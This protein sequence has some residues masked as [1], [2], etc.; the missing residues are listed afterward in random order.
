MN[1][2]LN[3]KSDSFDD[4]L[5]IPFPNDSVFSLKKFLFGQRSLYS[6]ILHLHLGLQLIA[7][8]TSQ[9]KTSSQINF[10]FELIHWLIPAVVAWPHCFVFLSK[11]IKY[12]DEHQQRVHVYHESLLWCMRSNVLVIFWFPVVFCLR[13]WHHIATKPNVL[14]DA[15]VN[16][17]KIKTKQRHSKRKEKLSCL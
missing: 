13:H 12:I 14:L 9:I 2:R 8:I 10:M 1:P 11:D 16:G 15:S 4:S 6:V 17:S 5:Y 3:Q 7:F